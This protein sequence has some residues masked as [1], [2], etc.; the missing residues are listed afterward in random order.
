MST[1]KIPFLSFGLLS[2]LSLHTKYNEILLKI[3]LF[4]ESGMPEYFTRFIGI[5]G[6]EFSCVQHV[7]NVLDS[8]ISDGRKIG[9]STSNV[10]IQLV[11]QWKDFKP[12]NVSGFEKFHGQVQF[13]NHEIYKT[14]TSFILPAWQTVRLTDFRAKISP[15]SN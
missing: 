10:F 11:E 6:K 3:T 1:I 7:K 8:R 15:K 13:K 2:F 4:Y 12:P 14:E 5:L 9:E